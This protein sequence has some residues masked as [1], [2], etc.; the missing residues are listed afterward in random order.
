MAHKHLKNQVIYVSN[1][2]Y[3]QL[4]TTNKTSKSTKKQKK[5]LEE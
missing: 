3:D 2:A 4:Q 1:R 5:E